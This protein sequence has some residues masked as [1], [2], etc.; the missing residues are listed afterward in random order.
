M[1]NS[2]RENR[3]RDKTLHFSEKILWWMGFI[4]ACLSSLMIVLS[5]IHFPVIYLFSLALLAVLGFFMQKR[6]YSKLREPF[7]RIFKTID[8]NPKLQ[9][10][11]DL[12][13]E[14][15]LICLLAAVGISPATDLVKLGPGA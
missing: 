6:L 3:N 9:G 10:L 8:F 15:V 14:L 11:M 13:L 12:S 5:V 2:K 4:F 1:S 7:V